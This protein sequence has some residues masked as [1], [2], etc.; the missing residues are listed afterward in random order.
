MVYSKAGRQSVHLSRRNAFKLSTSADTLITIIDR[1]QQSRQAQ[2]SQSIPN[3]LP[4]KILNYQAWHGHSVGR[5]RY[6]HYW[7]L[8]CA[9][10]AMRQLITLLSSVLL[11]CLWGRHAL[12]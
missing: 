9:R 8:N 7:A 6:K 10:E 3:E 4:K 11:L 5:A 1:R 12:K 2:M